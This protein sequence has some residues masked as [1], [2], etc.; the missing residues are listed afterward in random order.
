MTTQVRSRE[1]LYEIFKNAAEGINARLTDWSEG[2]INDVQAGSASTMGAELTF[3]ILQEFAKTFINSADGPEV[4][5]STD[6]LQTLIVDHYGDDFARPGAQNAV[7]VVRFYRAVDTAGDVEIP[8]GTIVKTV[9]DANG[10]AV[11]FET[12]TTVTMTALEIN[13]SIEAV[14]AGTGGNRDTDDIT[15]IESTLTD[16]TVEC[17]NDS[18]TE[19]GAAEFDDEDYRTWARN[20]IITL[21]GGTA[22]AIQAVAINV[23][24]IETATAIEKLQT[25]IEYD[26]GGASTIGSHFQIPHAYL[27]V[28]DANGEANDA[29]IDLVE[30]A[31]NGIRATGV[32][33]TVVAA[34]AV[35]IDWTL[36]LTLNPSGPNY[37]EFQND[38]TKIKDTMTKYIN[39]LATGVDF[40]R[41]TAEEAV[42]AVWGPSGTDDLT[43]AQT[44]TPTGEIEITEGQKPIAGTIDTE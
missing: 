42:M 3:V 29:L 31:I 28:A 2:A 23:S 38:T 14:E 8:A 41:D 21:K 37:T 5:E 43:V 27:Y 24:G 17:T 34:T 30:T 20:K 7:G 4:T 13:A 11:R 10:E 44:V 36:T 12:L 39:D 15:V 26:V 22:S 25:V 16:A 19:G 33:V 9:V 32:V 18:A 35:S 1:E 40:D 6:D